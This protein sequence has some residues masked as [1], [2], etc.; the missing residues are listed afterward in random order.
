MYQIFYNAIKNTNKMIANRYFY[1]IVLSLI[2]VNASIL[3]YGQHVVTQPANMFRDGDRVSMMPIN[4]QDQG[5]TGRNVFWNLRDVETEDNCH[6]VIYKELDTDK[7]RFAEREYDTRHY[8]TLRNDS[9]LLSGFENSYS[10]ANYE[11]PELYARFPMRYGDTMTGL[12]YG[13]GTYYDKIAFRTYGTYRTEADAYGTVILPDGSSYS[14]VIR[15]HMHRDKHAIFYSADSLERIVATPFPADTVS[16]LVSM[17]PPLVEEDVMLW[18]AKG[19]RYPI[20]KS[21]TV[22]V[23]DGAAVVRQDRQAFYCPATEQELITM[24]AVNE[25]IRRQSKSG[26][27]GQTDEAA[28]DIGF[29]YNMSF[30]TPGSCQLD[31]HLEAPMSVSYGVYTVTGTVVREAN[32]GTLS[33]GSHTYE[34]TWPK[35]DQEYYLLTIRVNDKKYV[36]KLP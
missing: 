36:E 5:R 35:R 28:G 10:Q 2:A 34:I 17:R 6:W 30:G 31:C 22:K 3:T 15:Q 33:E 23:H 24:D 21:V 13:H 29:A 18:Y 9:L 26:A 16:R 20:L 7:H 27:Y 25:T 4:Y 11:W 8:Y 14:G 12:F 32:L 1:H 19:Y